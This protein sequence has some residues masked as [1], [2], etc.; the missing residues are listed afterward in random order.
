MYIL[1]S[2]IS[3]TDDDKAKSMASMHLEKQKKLQLVDRLFE[4][5]SSVNLPASK[6]DKTRGMNM[7]YLRY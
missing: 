7:D 2:P 1:V 6:R 3:N 4:L 5:S